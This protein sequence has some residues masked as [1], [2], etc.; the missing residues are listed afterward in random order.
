MKPKGRIVMVELLIAFLFFSLS[1]VIALQ[2][3]A[4]GYEFSR[5]STLRAGALREAQSLADRLYTASSAEKLLKEAGF[6]KDEADYVRAQG[7]V[8]Y[9]VALSAHGTDAGVMQSMIVTVS[10]GDTVLFTLPV[11]RYEGGTTP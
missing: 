9:T 5:D 11:K 6:E 8:A 7:E 1:A 10:E 4:H 2:L 3:F